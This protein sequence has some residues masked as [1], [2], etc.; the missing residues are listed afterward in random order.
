MLVRLIWMSASRWPL[1]SVSAQG[2]ACLLMVPDL[3]L[4]GLV[5]RFDLRKTFF[6]V[7]AG[8][9]R[10]DRFA[11]EGAHFLGTDDEIL[12]RLGQKPFCGCG[13][14]LQ[15]VKAHVQ[16]VALGQVLFFRLVE[17]RTETTAFRIGFSKACLDFAE[18][19]A[20]AVSVFS[21]S[22]N[23]HVS[24]AVSLRV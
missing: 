7:V 19:G 24:R 5:L 15:G 6:S 11:V 20:V 18:L 10:F 14:R 21:L 16:A 22:V 17:G 4:A 3:A 23:R 2:R 9:G 8:D 12:S 1:R 13:A